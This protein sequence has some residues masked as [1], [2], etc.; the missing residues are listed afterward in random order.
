MSE[1]EDHILIISND[2]VHS[3]QLLTLLSSITRKVITCANFELGRTL[4]SNPD[5]AGGNFT[6]VFIEGEPKVAKE[7]EILAE[8][9]DLGQDHKI[10]FKVVAMADEPMPEKFQE[11]F[12]VGT[13]I[14]EKPANWFSLKDVL[15]NHGIDLRKVN[16]WEYKDCGRQPGGSNV[17]EL[18]ECP[19]TLSKEVDGMHG[20]N[21]GGRVCW[22]I[23]GT[24]CSGTKQGSFAS[25]M[26]SCQ[27]CNFFKVIQME[28]GDY[29]ESINSILRR[30]QK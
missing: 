26:K 20:G 18:G 5:L 16:C 1:S 23:S 24:F 25:K 3:G 30:L 28:E 14:L 19:A 17:A 12:P 8:I 9:L 29:F 15:N 27:T 21:L 22:A 4:L 11:K 6:L 13:C 10:G 2:L 7:Q